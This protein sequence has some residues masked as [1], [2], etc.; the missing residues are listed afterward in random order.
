MEI[1]WYNY[2]DSATMKADVLYMRNRKRCNRRSTVK[3]NHRNNDF[4]LQI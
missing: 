1:F 3:K 4:A 2:N